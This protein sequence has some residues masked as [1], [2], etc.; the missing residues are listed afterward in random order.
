MPKA[1]SDCNVLVAQ[2]VAAD[3]SKDYTTAVVLYRTAIGTLL[4]EIEQQRHNPHKRKQLKN[5][6]KELLRR[7]EELQRYL[8]DTSK[9]RPSSSTTKKQIAANKKTRRSSS[10]H[11]H[12][13]PSASTRT[14]NTRD[15]VHPVIDKEH[16][17]NNDRNNG[18][19]DCDN[20]NESE[21]E[22][23]W[24]FN[25]DLSFHMRSKIKTPSPEPTSDTV[26]GAE[27]SYL[28]KLLRLLGR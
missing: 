28:M 18:S 7:A 26:D 13:R 27:P 6:V 2:A 19:S 23:E 1:I 21:R 22:K 12:T 5:H 3:H 11:P 17:D 25:F 14:S 9:S 24:S 16:R 8:D 10:V 20:N 15:L 4:E